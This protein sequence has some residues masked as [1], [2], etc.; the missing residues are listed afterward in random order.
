MIGSPF[1]ESSHTKQEIKTVVN[2]S[3]HSVDAGV[4]QNRNPLRVMESTNIIPPTVQTGIPLSMRGTPVQG[5]GIAPPSNLMAGQMPPKPL[6]AA[7]AP[8]TSYGT[9]GN[10][11]LVT[12]KE[13]LSIP[14]PNNSRLVG[15]LK[16]KI[17]YKDNKPLMKNIK[18]ILFVPDTR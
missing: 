18:D 15:T 11:S 8:V 12:R 13:G 5:T 16:I 9:V 1:T 2:K 6:S 7:P 3:L 10:S 17:P 14:I 4:V